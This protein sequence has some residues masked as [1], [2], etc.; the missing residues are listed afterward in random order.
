M[1][2]NMLFD[3]MNIDAVIDIA[4]TV[5]PPVVSQER[6][7]QLLHY[8]L[9]TGIFYYLE[10]GEEAGW[11]TPSGYISIYVDG[12]Y[13]AA[14]RLAIL[15]TDGYFPELTVDHKNRIRND[16]RRAN[17][18]EASH[19]C[20]A[21]NSWLSKKNTTGIKGVSYI[22]QQRKWEARIKVD[23][24]DRHLGVR[25]SLLEAAYLRYAA[26]QCLGFPECDENSSAKQFI[27]RNK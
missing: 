15:Y 13:Y 7:K 3:E 5:R 2:V 26:E 27:E 11:I 18:R 4:I 23:R 9:D 10:N 19:Q 22:P 6:L 12:R 24:K 8:N 25:Y 20:Q 16:N 17:L 14:H 21:R 1:P